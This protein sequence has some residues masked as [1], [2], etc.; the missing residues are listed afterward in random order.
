MK[1]L[2]T[3]L[4]I[5]IGLMFVWI[6]YTTYLRFEPYQEPTAVE[7]L[8]ILNEN[9]QVKQGGTVSYL[10]NYCI[11][12]KVPTTNSRTIESQ[13]DNTRIY[14]LATTVSAGANP[15]C[16]KTT[17]NIPLSTDIPP[18]KYVIKSVGKYTVNQLEERT[19]TF[20]SEEFEII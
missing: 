19:K 5:S 9:H 15:G 20:T 18:G 14:F 16:N 1:H 11:S 17:I 3:L 4:L 10:L 12:K 7:P 13:S 6:A 8:Q 2:G